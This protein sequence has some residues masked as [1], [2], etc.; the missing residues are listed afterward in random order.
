MSVLR[1]VV[2]GKEIRLEL[3]RNR[4]LRS[5][6]LAFHLCKQPFDFGSQPS[7][8][9]C[10]ISIVKEG[11]G[12]GQKE[13]GAIEYNVLTLSLVVVRESK[14]VCI[15][16]AISKGFVSAKLPVPGCTMPCARSR[17][18]MFVGW[19]HKQRSVLCRGT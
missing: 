13:E 9:S 7:L 3:D 2:A 14:S 19:N 15:C 16:S 1:A 18:E 12:G 17:R 11:E 5:P 6:R 4:L 10:R 8:C